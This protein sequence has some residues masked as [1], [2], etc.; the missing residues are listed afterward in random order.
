M[1]GLLIRVDREGLE[2]VTALKIIKDAGIDAVVGEQV[3]NFAD[4]QTSQGII[5][6]DGNKKGVFTRDRRP[7][8][9]AFALRERWL[10]AGEADTGS[11]R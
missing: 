11:G 5:R 3:W 1:L 9:A 2:A 4:F 6:V 10:A 8:A 7:K